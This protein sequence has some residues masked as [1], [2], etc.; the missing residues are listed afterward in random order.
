VRRDPG[1]FAIDAL[2]C[3]SAVV[4]DGKLYVHGAGWNMLSTP[5]LPFA[6]PR[7]GLAIVITVPYTETNREHEFSV[8]LTDQDGHDLPIGAGMRDADGTVVRDAA[9]R[10]RFTIGRPPGLTS[11]D[12]QPLPLALNIDQMEFGAAGLFSFSLAINDDE[13]T[14]LS[15]RIQSP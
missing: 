2:L 11:G 15:F 7:I 9:I 13:Q 3:D 10:G 12:S 14:R 1:K 8:R 4:A 5:Q 6:Q